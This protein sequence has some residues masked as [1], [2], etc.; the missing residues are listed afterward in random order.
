MGTEDGQVFCDVVFEND[1]TE[2]IIEVSDP[3]GAAASQ[4]V[5]IEVVPTAPPLALIFSPTLDNYYY[6]GTYATFAGRVTDAED[7][8]E[9][10]IAVWNSS[11]DGDI[12]VDT[13]PDSEGDILGAAYLSEG[14]HFL[15]LTVT[16]SSG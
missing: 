10:L 1:D 13:T 2:I 5:A 3:E 4:A 15:K 12:D 14:E 11:I 9:T 7:Q 6:S 8:E 16:D